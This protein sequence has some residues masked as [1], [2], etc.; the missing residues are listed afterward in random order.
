[1]IVL[2]DGETGGSGSD[3]VDLVTVMREEL[4]ITVSTV[5]IGDQANIPLLKRIAQ[6]GGGFFHHTYD[7]R[8]LPQIVLQ[9]LRE[10]P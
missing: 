7:P 10:K 4:K 3:Y 1:M 9:Q 8:T 2:S 5:A 6:Y